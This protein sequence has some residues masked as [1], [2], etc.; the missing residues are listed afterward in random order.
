MKGYVHCRPK[1]RLS[2][3]I[4]TWFCISFHYVLLYFSMFVTVCSKPCLSKGLLLMVTMSCE[5]SHPLLIRSQ[6]SHNYPSARGYPQRLHHLL[7]RWML[8]MEAAAG[9]YTG[10]RAELGYRHHGCEKHS[11]MFS[12]HV[13]GF[14]LDLSRSVCGNTQPLGRRLRPC[15]VMTQDVVLPFC[16]AQDF[17]PNF[18]SFFPSSAWCVR[19]ARIRTCHVLKD[20]FS[21]AGFSVC[22]IQ[23]VIFLIFFLHC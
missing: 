4:V 19:E 16:N 12:G 20:S 10:A 3:V 15:S 13:C 1:L 8:A 2:S 11:E 22:F 23:L 6:P 14:T 9:I 21:S 17:F 7:E 5:A 18:F